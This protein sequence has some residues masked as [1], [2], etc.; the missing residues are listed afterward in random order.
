MSN[1]SFRGRLELSTGL[2]LQ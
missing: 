2:K 1:M